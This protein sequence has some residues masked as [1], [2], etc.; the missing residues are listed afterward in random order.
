MS[1]RAEMAAVTERFVAAV[2][3]GDAA[4]MAACYTE[5]AIG[6]YSNMDFITGRSA[7]QKHYQSHVDT[8]IVKAI[9]FETVE[10]EE[11]GDTAYEIGKMTMFGPDGKMV[12]AGKY[13]VIWK[14]E[15]GQ[16]K[17]HRDI[18]NTSLPRR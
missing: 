16:W 13:L 7:I 12:D 10:L 4:G 14:R 2:S 15:G 17:Y 11:H 18:A 8:G 1:D 9:K 6:M 5:K 3:R